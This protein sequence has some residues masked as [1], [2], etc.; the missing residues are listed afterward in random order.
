MDWDH[1]IAAAGTLF[2][3]LDPPGVSPLV[4]GLLQ[5][6]PPERRRKVL[7]RELCFV[8][9]LLLFFF[10]LGKS[11]LGWMGITASSLNISGGIMLF[12]I[13]VG[14]VFPTRRSPHLN[15]SSSELFIVPVSVPLIVGP[16][17]I[18]L[19]MMQAALSTDLLS[20]LEGVLSILLAWGPAALLLYFSDCLL[21]LL[22]EKGTTALTRLM[23]TILVLL[24]VQM[25]LN[26]VT[27]YIVSLPGFGT[28]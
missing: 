14:M 21:N 17:A 3:V 24:A 19:V 26:G 16:A 12:L 9:V 2:L 18:S 6:I 20:R 5:Q 25:V 10:F 1:I 8:L 7:L 23:G 27:E 15:L 22:G 13:A 4:Q 28:R 11:I